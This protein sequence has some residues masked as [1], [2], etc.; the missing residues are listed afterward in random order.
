MEIKNIC[1]FLY[2]Y[3]FVFASTQ[4]PWHSPNIE[5]KDFEAD[6]AMKV[7]KVNGERNSQDDKEGC[8][9]ENG[10]PFVSSKERF[11]GYLSY[12]Q[13][14]RFV[15]FL[16]I[17]VNLS[18]VEFWHGFSPE[19]VVKGSVLSSYKSTQNF[20]CVLD[21]GWSNKFLK[22]LTN[23]FEWQKQILK[24]CLHFRYRPF[25]EFFSKKNP[26]RHSKS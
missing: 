23:F 5:S 1:I 10:A 12:K 4:T 15:I 11:L 25:H 3:L 24:V 21:T 6:N 26:T 2:I 16:L 19:N 8:Q 9:A 17:F 18:I 22:S 7:S 13:W 14:C 20:L